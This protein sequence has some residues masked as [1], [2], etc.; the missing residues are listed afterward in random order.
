MHGEFHVRFFPRS[1]RNRF[2]GEIVIRLGALLVFTEMRR[3]RA[4]FGF[5]PAARRN[6]RT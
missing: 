4:A 2:P 6:E 3:R 1:Y 5:L